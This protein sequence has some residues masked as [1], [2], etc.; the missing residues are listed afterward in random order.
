[1]NKLLELFEKIKA[2][3]RPDLQKVLAQFSKVDAN[4]E[5]IVKYSRDEIVKAEA[6]IAEHLAK[7]NEHDTTATRA[8]NV[9][10]NIKKLID[11]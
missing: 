9:Q 10:A 3:L 2:L 7:K 11:V 6:K 5:K 1:M 8:S 4:L